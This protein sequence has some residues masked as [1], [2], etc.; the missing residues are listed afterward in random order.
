MISV[1]LGVLIINA[2]L[3]VS[4]GMD[5]TLLKFLVDASILFAPTR[6][7]AFLCIDQNDALHLLRAMSNAHLSYDIRISNHNLDMRVSRENRHY[8]SFLLDLNCPEAITILRQANESALFVGPLKWLILQDLKDRKKQNDSYLDS[9]FGNLAIFPDSEL[10]L[11]QRLDKNSTRLLSPY[12]PSPYH[13]LIIE[14]IGLWDLQNG[15]TLL[16]HDVSSRRR[17]NLA[18]TPLKSCLVVTDPDTINHLTDYQDKHSDTIT[19]TNY[20]WI[21]H[22]VRMMNATVTFSIANTWGYRSKNGSWSGMIGQLARGEIDI[23]G[24]AT[25]FTAERIGV[26]QYISLYTPTSNV[27]TLPFRRSVWIA[28]GVFMI[29]IFCLLHLTL[30]WEWFNTSAEER[31]RRHWS[32]NVYQPTMS[33][34]L[35]ILVGAV[36]QQGSSYEA[37]AIPARIIILMLLVATLSLYASYTAN[38]VALL[39]STT[40]SITTL[41]DLLHSPLKIGVHDIVYN[42]YYF[43]SFQDPIRKTIYEQKVAPKGRK[44]AWMNLEEGVSRL[45]QGLFAFHGELG[46]VYKIVQETFNEDEKCGF[47]EIDYLNVLDPLIAIQKESPYLEI[48]R[49]GALKIHENGLQTREIRRLYT[50]KPVCHKHAS[51]VSVGLTEC[52]AAFITLSYGTLIAFTIFILEIIWYKRGIVEDVV[53]PFDYVK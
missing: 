26:V 27:F 32:G 24:T 16:N 6:M 10:V 34:N 7:T 37:R 18:N 28:I 2:C 4:S 35:L 46:S 23:G 13:K 52:Y 51:F 21:M 11:A 25:F 19:K 48:I 44:S 31:V 47:Q 36:S 9:V 17:R 40:D 45:R 22:L 20:P 29:L 30:K 49:I 5:G 53:Q 8:V 43:E 42:R 14:E 15:V 33:D 41:D 38:I 50:K 1:L 3:P 12:R 39:Q